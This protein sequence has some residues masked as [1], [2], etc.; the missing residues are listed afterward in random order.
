MGYEILMRELGFEQLILDA[1]NGKVKMPKYS[2]D[3]PF[4]PV[5][6]FPPALIPIWSSRAWPGYVGIVTS[7]FGGTEHGF[8]RYFSEGQTMSE[9]ALT[10]DQLKAWLAFE[11]LCE[12]PDEN[13]VGDFAEAI[14]LC[15]RDRVEDYFSDCADFSDLIKLD[16][17]KSNPPKY[18][19]NG[20][21]DSQPSWVQQTVN[22]KEISNLIEIGDYQQ[23]WN[24]IN[25]PGLERRDIVDLIEKIAP[26]S[27]NARFYKLIECWLT[28]V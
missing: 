16:E 25:S 4:D 2:L 24:C 3:A 12:I 6:G 9:I 21:R 13:E 5:Y 19:V 8:V 1:Y 15:A 11:F 20:S 28:S 18:L 14:G 23:A 27:N 26:Y 17:F 22:K 10:F 7:W